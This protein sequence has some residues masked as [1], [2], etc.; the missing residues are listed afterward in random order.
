[1]KGLFTADEFNGDCIKDK[2]AKAAY[3]KKVIEFVTAANN[4]APNVKIGS[5]ISGRDAESTNILLQLLA[6]VANRGVRT[7]F[8]LLFIDYFLDRQ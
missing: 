2:E 7:Q 8:P 6:D 3:L 4:R 5:I 1:M